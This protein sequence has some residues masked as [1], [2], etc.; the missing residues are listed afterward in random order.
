MTDSN[1]GPVSLAGA[2]GERILLFSL[3][4]ARKRAHRDECFPKPVAVRD[5]AFL[6]DRQ[7]LRDYQAAIDAARALPVYPD[8]SGQRPPDNPPEGPEWK[9]LP[10]ARNYQA[11]HRGYVRSVDRS[12]DGRDYKGVVL[13]P[14]LGNKVREGD[15]VYLLVDVRRDDGSKWTGT[16]HGFVLLAHVGEPGPGQETRHGPGGPLD[17]RWPENICYGTKRENEADKPRAVRQPKPKT[18]CMN[19]GYCGGYVTSGGR[20]CHD[21]VVIVGEA[22]A[23]MLEEGAD[24][25]KAAEVLGYSSAAGLYKLAVKYGGLRVYVDRAVVAARDQPDGHAEQ[26]QSWLRRVTNGV[27]AWLDSGDV[28]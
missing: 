4:A 10:G 26:P 9:P 7:A 12:V 23:A 24:L 1:R 16:V 28:A 13:K 18:P 8:P 11:S 27:R 22:G 19:H 3:D 14:R 20:R 15:T 17:N 2:V 5:S 6:Y 25:E 21:C